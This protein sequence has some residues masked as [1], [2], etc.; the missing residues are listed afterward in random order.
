MEKKRACLVF[1]IPT[2]AALLRC[3]RLKGLTLTWT[4]Q[5]GPSLLAPVHYLWPIGMLSVLEHELVWL[6]AGLV[7]RVAVVG[8]NETDTC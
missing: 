8:S 7:R 3:C 5:T 4:R 6:W 1:L 2:S